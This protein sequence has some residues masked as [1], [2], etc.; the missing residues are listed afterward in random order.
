MARRQA[1]RRRLSRAALA[2]TLAAAA[3]V[4]SGVGPAAAAAA[5]STVTVDPSTGLRD[6]DTVSVTVSDADF[7]NHSLLQCDAA[8]L[9]AA[10]N[11]YPDPWGVLYHCTPEA[12][13]VRFTAEPGTTTTVEMAVRESFTPPFSA[14]N[15]VTC[16]D[17]PG[18]CLI[19]DIDHVLGQFPAG[20]G[21]YAP[22]SI[23]GT[24][25]LTLAPLPA[26]S[27]PWSLTATGARFRP[28]PVTLAPCSATWAS[29]PDPVTADASCGAPV[30]VT[31]DAAG[32]FAAPVTVSDPLTAHDGGSIPCGFDGCRLVAGYTGEP[33]RVSSA[34]P[35]ATPTFTAS[36]TSQLQDGAIIHVTISGVDTPAAR[37]DLCV[38]IPPGVPPL[39]EG[40]FC[41]PGYERT[42]TLT[43]GAGEID[44][45][46]GTGTW[47]SFDPPGTISCREVP[48]YLA[49]STPT[50]EQI[51]DTIPVTYA[52]RPFITLGSSADGWDEGT[53]AQLHGENLPTSVPL[54]SV[55]VCNLSGTSCEP[56]TL[57]ANTTGTIDIPVTLTQAP[58][59]TALCRLACMVRAESYL[60][61][62]PVLTTTYN[63]L[64]GSVSLS[65]DAALADGQAVT[66]TGTRIMGD[67][68]GRPL[69]FATGEW[70]P[71]QVCDR[72]VRDAPATLADVLTKCATPPGDANV[73]VV[74]HTTTNTVSVPGRFTAT[75]GGATFDCTTSAGACVVG[76]VRW[77]QDATVTTRLRP[78]T[79]ATG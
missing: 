68:V 5:T 76:L 14:G 69:L 22:I 35:F 72:S 78:L 2:L 79:F 46:A 70:A 45:P 1:S 50:G 51:G 29:A 61:L 30:D 4:A 74:D 12:D 53:V 77:E 7:A 48:C 6:G 75:L 65:P 52:P 47:T 37:V 20:A 3:V 28:E 43:G 11:T 9:T 63:A 55:S 36:P 8:W 17:A 34:L 49:A 71:V 66:V 57:V 54:W 33:A 64:L 38:D 60:L 24:P 40:R 41:F 26:T 73:T 21:G 10:S 25:T 31:P 42:V 59:N 32:A 16:G 19:V 27:S 15:P 13:L 67:Y 62:G 23:E 44:F 18:D 56:S 39:P 58:G